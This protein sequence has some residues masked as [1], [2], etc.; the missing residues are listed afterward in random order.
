MTIVEYSKKIDKILIKDNRYK[1]EAYIF[2]LSALNH[3]VAGLPKH[4]HI[5]GKEL[6]EGMREFALEQFGPLALEVFEYWGIK[7]TED[8][9]EIVF[10]LV[11]QGLLS[12]TE[13]DSRNDFKN[14]FDFRDVFKKDFKFV[15]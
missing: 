6:L 4:R 1:K 14:I 9:G 15:L 8:I 13:S 7:V 5:I 10:N 2:V 12:K 3:T 11:E